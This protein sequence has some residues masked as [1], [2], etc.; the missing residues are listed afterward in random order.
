MTSIRSSSMKRQLPMWPRHRS[1]FSLG[2]P[3]IPDGR[4]AAPSQSIFTVLDETMSPVGHVLRASDHHRSRTA[5]A[6]AQP[7]TDRGSLLAVPIL[8]RLSLAIRKRKKRSGHNRQNKRSLKG[9]RIRQGY[10]RNS[11]YVFDAD[12][13]SNP[14]T[15]L[16]SKGPRFHSINSLERAQAEEGLLP[17]WFP[18]LLGRMVRR[19]GR[20]DPQSCNVVIRH[21]VSAPSVV[22]RRFLTP[23]NSM[24][25]IC[26]HADRRPICA[27]NNRR[28]GC[29]TLALAVGRVASN[30]QVVSRGRGRANCGR[31]QLCRKTKQR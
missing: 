4:P 26:C 28:I 16:G 24:K 27:L 17:D 23:P 3:R 2:V 29:A 15:L 25:T 1:P 6:C 13:R 9:W 30:P 22:R 10:G 31:R 21:G 18:P 19:H 20:C 8:V 14:L 7:V 5:S 12:R 11:A